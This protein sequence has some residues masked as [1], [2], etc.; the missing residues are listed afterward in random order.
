MSGMNSHLETIASTFST[1]Q[2]H[3]QGIMAHELKFDKEQK[4]LAE[5]KG[6]VRRNYTNY[7]AH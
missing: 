1:T 7:E 4:D 5:K 6:F 3:E 2:Q